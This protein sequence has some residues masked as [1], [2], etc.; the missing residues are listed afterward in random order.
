MQQYYE[1]S[2]TI[3]GGECLASSPPLTTVQ[4]SAKA[5]LLVLAGE[6]VFA[7]RTADLLEHLGRL[8]LGVQ[9]LARFAAEGLPA[10]HGIEPVKFVL[11]GDRR[12][13]HHLPILLRQHVAR[14]VI[15]M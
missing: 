5:C 3:V 10:E 7:D 1:N 4:V 6:I 8:A 15:L 13:T 9:G 2:I 12:E 14:E 11:V